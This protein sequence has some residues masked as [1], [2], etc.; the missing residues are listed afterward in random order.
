MILPL[1]PYGLSYPVI[2]DEAKKSAMANLVTEAFAKWFERPEAKSPIYNFN[3]DDKDHQEVFK[4][5]FLGLVGAF[6]P[7]L[8]NKDF[9]VE[10]EFRDVVNNHCGQHDVW[11][12]TND[13]KRL[14]YLQ[15]VHRSTIMP[16]SG[17]DGT[18]EQGEEQV[19][20]P[21]T[22]I[23]LGPRLNFIKN[24]QNVKNLLSQ[25]GYNDVE[26][27]QSKSPLK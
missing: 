7:I 21:I 19:L 25:Y 13:G 10:H 8:K 22:E 15:A 1:S 18:I 23:I 27:K 24:K 6:A 11:V 3:K 2:Y 4:C 26:V 16:P 12:E 17:K 9:E 5:L 20:L 14:V